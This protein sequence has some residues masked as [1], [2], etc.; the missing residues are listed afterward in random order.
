MAVPVVDGIPWESDEEDEPPKTGTPR[1]PASPTPGGSA[2][3][4][5]KAVPRGT[6]G[7]GRPASTTEH[8]VLPPSLKLHGRKYAA[9]LTSLLRKRESSDETRSVD[10]APE[11][12]TSSLGRRVWFKRIVQKIFRI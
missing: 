6:S 2:S 4:F 1:M 11:A 7:D 10:A 9:S 8:G 12:E 5:L 3:R